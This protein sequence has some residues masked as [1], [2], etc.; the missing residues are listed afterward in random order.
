M[1]RKPFTIFIT[2]VFGVV[3]LTVWMV[4]LVASHDSPTQPSSHW[5]ELVRETVFPNHNVLSVS[6]KP[7]RSG[8][9]CQ[10]NLRQFDGAKEEWALEHNKTTN[11]P[12]PTMD[13]LRPYLGRGTNGTL[14]T[15]P[16]GGEYILGR[17]DEPTKCS[18]SGADHNH[19]R[20]EQKLR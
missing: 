3:V 15:C 8:S 19:E 14:P 18:L 9:A 1:K 12:A 6:P 4:W 20:Y 16:F 17:L 2:G 5:L 11:D 13:D 7:F 10:N